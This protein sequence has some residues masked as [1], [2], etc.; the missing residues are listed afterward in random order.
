M[1]ALAPRRLS[2]A[3]RLLGEGNGRLN[4]LPY[5]SSSSSSLTPMPL[6]LLSRLD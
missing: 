6:P 2:A 4:W 3:P 5:S 1:P